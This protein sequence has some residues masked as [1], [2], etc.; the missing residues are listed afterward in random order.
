MH[1]T[2]RMIATFTLSCAAAFGQDA[3]ATY[4]TKCQMCH[5]AD[6]AGSTPAGQKLGTRSFKAP[7]VAKETDAEMANIIENGKNKMPKYGDKL[8]KDEIEALVKY[9]HQLQK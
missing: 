9:V 5:G 2:V 7:E 3:A 8:K 1:R 4:K 6:G